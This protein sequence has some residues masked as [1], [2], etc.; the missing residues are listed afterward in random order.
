MSD[1]RRPT[2]EQMMALGSAAVEA[3]RD[4]PPD[5]DAWAETFAAM[6]RL[7]G[8]AR[9]HVLDA[10]HESREFVRLVSVIANTA[11]EMRT[12]AIMAYACS[13]AAVDDFLAKV[14]GDLDRM[15]GEGPAD[16]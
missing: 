10:K 9:Q 15:R 3:Y 7:C 4:N 6:E 2:A 11:V 5:L 13:G 12:G 14:A 16:G 1:R 8:Y